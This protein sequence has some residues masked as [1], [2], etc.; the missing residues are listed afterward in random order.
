MRFTKTYTGTANTDVDGASPG[1][2]GTS[3]MIL[4]YLVTIQNICLTI[5]LKVACFHCDITELQELLL[6]L[7]SFLLSCFSFT[8]AAFGG[9]RFLVLLRWELL[10]LGEGGADVVLSTCATFFCFG[11]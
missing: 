5:L 3:Q 2:T 7:P 9:R 8:N 1:S 10:F 6:N 11:L 4:F